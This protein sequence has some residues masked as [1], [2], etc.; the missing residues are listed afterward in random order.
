L[1]VQ[2]LDGYRQP[3]EG[4]S[5]GDIDRTE[6]LRCRIFSKQHK[7]ESESDVEGQHKK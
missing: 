4:N 7:R 5:Y 3:E 2:H 6:E 1:E